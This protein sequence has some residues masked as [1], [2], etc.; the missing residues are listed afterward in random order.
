[1]ESDLINGKLK[2]EPSELKGTSIL[3]MLTSLLALLAA[4][5]GIF[6]SEVYRELITT[7]AITEYLILGSV[8]QDIIT[9]PVSIAL[10]I[11][12]FLYIRVGDRRV[13]TAMAG[14]VSYIFYGYALY[15]I[16]GQYTRLYLVY[17]VIFG[18]SA[19]GLM[20][21]VPRL[22]HRSS[23]T[24]VPRGLRR[25]IAGFLLLI[26]AVLAPVWI[27]RMQP[28]IANRAP[29]ELYGVFVLDLAVVFPA[30]GIIAL[31]LLRNNA[32]F[33]LL[34]AAALVKVFTLC[35]SVGLGEFIKPFF[36]FPQDMAMTAIFITLTAVSAILS[37][38]IFRK[39]KAD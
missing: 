29:G 16:Q 27:M 30:F 20:F 4:L 12:S 23:R 34:T 6:S 1:M 35:L 31:N 25:G 19:Y 28:D 26:L 7:K 8:V 39:I 22:I 36:G 2:A 9:V 11:L 17:L 18:A 37:V 32:A 10:F 38:L 13:L 5:A 33:D 14:L 21:I 15:S 24:E 3:L